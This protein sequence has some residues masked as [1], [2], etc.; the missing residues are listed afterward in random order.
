MNCGV[1]ADGADDAG[2]AD[3]DS[4]IAAFWRREICSITPPWRAK[5]PTVI[6][7]GVTASTVIVSLSKAMWWVEVMFWANIQRRDLSS[8]RLSD[9]TE[10]GVE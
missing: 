6:C 10:C 9:L 5:T 4:W 3:A 8:G 7:L 1:G 2:D